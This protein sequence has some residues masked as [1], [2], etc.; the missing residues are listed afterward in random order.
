MTAGAVLVT[1]ATGTVGRHVVAALRARGTEV[2]RAVRVVEHADDRRFDF[3]DPTSWEAALDGV[4][5]LF[6]MRPPAISDVKGL[7]RPFV[8][9]AARRS[10]RHVVVLSV[11]GVNPAM[12]HWRLERDVKASGI[13]WT[14][15]RPAYFMQNLETAWRPSIRDQGVLRMPAGRGRTSF[16]DTRDVADIAALAL[17]EP[18]AHRGRTATPTG[19]EA[20]SWAAVAAALSAELGRPVRYAP[21]GFR[22]ARRELTD[23]GAPTA[24]VN[25]QLVIG[26]VARA[27]LAARVTDDVADLLGR[28]PRGLAAYLHE[29]RELWR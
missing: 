19:A 26:A 15:L 9:L 29:E 20:F 22:T 13:P 16:V 14:M 1:G 17:R 10:V 12:P 21:I 27:G 23:G 28:P 2:R 7:I 5:R 11:M 4:D 24:Y 3:V 18:L 8:H 25:V 6:L